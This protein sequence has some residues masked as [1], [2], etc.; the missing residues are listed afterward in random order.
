MART[1]SKRPSPSPEHDGEDSQRLSLREAK[2]VKQEK[3]T[4][5]HTPDVDQSDADEDLPDLDLEEDDS[6]EGSES[7][8]EEP[9]YKDDELVA[10]YSAWKDSQ[11][12]YMGREPEAG[13][14]KSISLV[15]FMCHRHLTV[16]FGPKMNFLVGHN[17]SGKSAV[18]TAIA[19]ALGG[20]A[21]T[22]GRGQGLKDLI[23]K[24]AEKST[25]T[26]TL[27]NS[28]LEAFKPDLYEPYIVIE[29]TLSTNGSSAYKFK[30]SKD[31]KVLA[32]KRTELTA[33]C[34][35]FQINIDSPLTIL[36]QDQ[37]RSF[38]QNSD[39]HK[40]Y[41]FFLDGTQLKALADS[42]DTSK[43]NVV[44]LENNVRRQTE[45]VPI[46]HQKIK[47][48]ERKMVAN[49]KIV[50]QRNRCRHILNEL[51][52]AYVIERER[53]RDEMRKAVA[54]YEGKADTAELEANN[55]QKQCV[56]LADEIRRAERD[57][58][59][60]EES[61]KPLEQAIRVARE[62]HKS[63]KKDLLELEQEDINAV[64]D[65]IEAERG[66]L[67][68]LQA[69]IDA[70][71]SVN[72]DAQ[73]EEFAKL[74]SD[75]TKFEEVLNRF[76]KEKP[77]LEQQHVA[78][79]TERKNALQE[80]DEI[81]RRAAD[82]QATSKRIQEK[83][84][85]LEKQSLNR[86]SAFGTG[87]EHV[88]RDV[89]RAKWVHSPPIGPLGMHVKLE[90]MSYSE[91]MHSVL[92][93]HLCS[94]A[95]R[96]A[97]DRQTLRNILQKHLR[98]GYRPG[99]GAVQIPQIH[100]HSGDIFDYS[101][102]DL[103]KFAPTVLSKLEFDNEEVLRLLINLSKI[104]QTFVARTVGEAN[105]EMRRL[106][107]SR[108]LERVSYLSADLQSITGTIS[109]KQSGPIA[110]WRGNLLFTRD[111]KGEIDRQ[112]AEL[113]ASLA[114]L[115]GLEQE[116]QVAQDKIAA[117]DAEMKK[118]TDDRNRV[119]KGIQP[120]TNKLDD[121]R[122]R[123]AEMTS[124]E[125]EGLEEA[126]EERI[127]KIE[128]KETRLQEFMQQKE[129]QEETIEERAE[130]IRSCQAELD[131]HSPQRQKQHELLEKL[132]TRRVDTSEK[133]KH[134]ER[135]RNS[136]LAMRQEAEER[137]VD[138]QASVDDWTRRA[139]EFCK[140]DVR[141][142]TDKNVDDLG[143]ER[144]ALE[145]A[146]KE[147]EKQVGINTQQVAAELKDKKRQLREI[148]T[149]IRHLR[150]LAKLLK[151]AIHARRSWWAL[152]RSHIAVRVKTA[153]VVFESFR[154]M[155][156]RLG[157]DHGQERLQL[158]VHNST[159]GED[160]QGHATQRS[161]YKTAQV[162]SGGE[163][164]FSTVSLLLALWSTVPCPIRALDEWDVFLDHANRRVAAKSLMDGARESDGKQFI[165]ITPQDMAGIDTSGP[166]KKV[167]RMADP[168]R[169][170]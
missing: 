136:Y 52:W 7:E 153:F 75:R 16:D 41:K 150:I 159:R 88:M 3:V 9:D 169:N 62:R 34:E 97:R 109:N 43:S 143:K 164:S 163:R 28:G 104:E 158:V 99:N 70:K 141:I 113:Q 64:R 96:D 167:I 53:A 155:D 103:S 8:F 40:L 22:T 12:N 19:V 137:L 69:K 93:N 45:A 25:I 82:E 65:D 73:R 114:R 36:T 14:L 5:R 146:I 165:L 168:T 98:S 67:G 83:I 123:L 59:N 108:T 126:R 94:F 54:L 111:L 68:I 2:R 151:E 58:Q 95:V 77:R 127:R 86:L 87:L 61:R 102:G 20:K 57:M 21:M 116:R 135:A 101:R 91:L 79:T 125:M 15:D 26:L 31:G 27:T 112:R 160:D 29:R 10:A 60:F 39:S 51:A 106:H 133:A 122:K 89:Q 139:A 17:G 48:L 4:S 138:Y 121:I 76:R 81:K 120:V 84:S 38:L 56:H 154:E 131:E 129:K 78:K 46:L 147:A 35:N 117:I 37:A 142:W 118:I 156:G 119:A 107:N 166:D 148:E 105:N 92:G 149:S 74:S 144:A 6:D 55:H 134:Y 145:A 90:D 152:T 63:A 11:R 42:Y 140:S 161:H 33:I 124:T 85:N 66:G 47:A 18:L 100:L 24:G 110:R 128:S 50:Q 1:A 162:L 32:N 170:Q 71:L 132:L 49:D 72:A 23:R 44:Q 80:V 130:E 157:F 30:A 115:E 13:V